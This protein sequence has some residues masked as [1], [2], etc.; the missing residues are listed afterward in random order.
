MLSR[1]AVTRVDVQENAGRLSEEL[2]STGARMAKQ[3]PIFVTSSIQLITNASQNDWL[4][5]P[6]F[7]PRNRPACSKSRSAPANCQLI[8]F[9]G[10]ARMEANAIFTNSR[11]QN[12]LGNKK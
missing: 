2:D 11:P 12:K 7:L 9:T 1:L 3:R 5:Q 8:I 10:S 4:I 6:S